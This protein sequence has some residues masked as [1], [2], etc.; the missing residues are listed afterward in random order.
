MRYSCLHRSSRRLTLLASHRYGLTVALAF[1]AGFSSWV[2]YVDAKYYTAGLL[3]MTGASNVRTTS[4]FPRC[5]L[6]D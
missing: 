3:L 4:F 5:L 2:F 6:A 1:W